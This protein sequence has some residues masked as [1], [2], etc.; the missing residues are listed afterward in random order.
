LWV[1]EQVILTPLPEPPP[2]RKRMARPSEPAPTVQMAVPVETAAPAHAQA[3]HSF[4][5]LVETLR[6]R[7]DAS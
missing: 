5:S 6:A 1:I 7:G 3:H 4:L 2:R